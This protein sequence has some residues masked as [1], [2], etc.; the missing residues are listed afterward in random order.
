MFGL[1][2]RLPVSE[3]ER[4]WVDG[5][6]D[7]LSRL[8]GPGR[9]IN[10][11]V[12]VPTDEFFPDAYDKR[13]AGL[14]ALFRRVCGYMGVD[15]AG[16]D[17]EVIPDASEVIEALPAYEYA[18]EGPAGLHFGATD[19]ERPLIAVK[20]STLK[21]PLAA[22]AVLA[23]ELGHVI[24]L[25][26]GHLRR[27]EPD[28]EP[29][30][31][32]AT[33]FLGLGVFTANASRRF[34]QFQDERKQGWRMNRLGY[35]SEVVYGYALARFAQLRRETQPTWIAHL[36]TNQKAYFLQSAAWLRTRVLPT[37]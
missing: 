18:G 7:R 3:E 15:P 1:R 11:R 25:G 37:Q 23:H 17:L 20:Q 36:S 22:V 8:L 6:F 9:M 12:V 26:G 21:D 27:D 10:A 13:D 30:T 29:M 14:R 2:P 31:D 16:V 34:V 19:A 4:L 24:L 28:M 32:L 5:G 33:V 35:L